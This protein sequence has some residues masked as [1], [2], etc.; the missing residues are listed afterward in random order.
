MGTQDDEMGTQDDEMGVQDDAPPSFRAPHRHSV[1]DT[2]S[3]LYINQRAQL[4]VKMYK[5]SLP[6]FGVEFIESCIFSLSIIDFTML[7]PIPKPPLL[8]FSL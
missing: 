1:L 2:E 5:N 6:F 7:R 8:I 4:E 3:N